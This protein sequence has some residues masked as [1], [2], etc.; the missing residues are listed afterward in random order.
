[1]KEYCIKQS[2]EIQEFFQMFQNFVATYS[3]DIIAGNFNNMFL[4]NYTINILQLLV[5]FLLLIYN[6]IFKKCRKI[7]I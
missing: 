4:Y 6:L 7:N 1:M 5:L 3:L 2:M